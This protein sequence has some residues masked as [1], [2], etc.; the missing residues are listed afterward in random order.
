MRWSK[1]LEHKRIE[2]ID[3]YFLELS[4]RKEKGVFFY[5]INGISEE[6]R[7]FLCKYYDSARKQG[8]IIEGRIANPTEGNLSYYNEIM[9]MDFKMEESFIDTSL[10]K[11]L[12]RMSYAQRG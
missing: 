4:K 11:W 1:L 12:P 3:D 2:H 10:K 7:S 6:V 5:R 9:G 8:V